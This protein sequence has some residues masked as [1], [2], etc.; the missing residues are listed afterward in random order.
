MGLKANGKYTRIENIVI[1]KNRIPSGLNGGGGGKDI[2][3]PDYGVSIRY[4]IYE[5]EKAEKQVSFGEYQ[6]EFD[7]L[8]E[9][10]PLTQGYEILKSRVPDFK[11]AEDV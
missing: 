10:S 8:V 3:K 7:G 11:E 5:N 2:E 6:G 9:K 4:F 1:S